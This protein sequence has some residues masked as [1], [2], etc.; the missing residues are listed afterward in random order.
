MSLSRDVLMEMQRIERMIWD[1]QIPLARIHHLIE[2][3]ER[4][5]PMAAGALRLTLG[6]VR[7][8]VH[9]A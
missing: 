9:L 5:D 1:K 6:E 7:S 4:R 2:L 8:P 3:L